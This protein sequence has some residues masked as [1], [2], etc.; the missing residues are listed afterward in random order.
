MIRAIVAICIQFLLY[1][2]L[3]ILSWSTGIPLGIL[4]NPIVQALILLWIYEKGAKYDF[5]HK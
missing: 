4:A 2:L 5:K 1:W 3:G